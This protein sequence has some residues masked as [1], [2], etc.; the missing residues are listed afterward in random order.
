MIKVMSK[1]KKTQTDIQTDRWAVAT[2]IE[3]MLG[4]DAGSWYG[5]NEYYAQAWEDMKN[6]SNLRLHSQ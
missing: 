1:L 5:L 6:Y 2:K 3:T 4:V